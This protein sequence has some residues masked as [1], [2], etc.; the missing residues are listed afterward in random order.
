MFTHHCTRKMLSD[1]YMD[2]ILLY[3]CQTIF[4]L[5]KYYIHSLN[6]LG[7]AQV[8]LHIPNFLATK[9]YSHQPNPPKQVLFF[10]F[11]SK[12]EEQTFGQRTPAI[13]WRKLN[14]KV[15][16]V[17]NK[18]C[19]WW[20]QINYHLPHGVVWQQKI[21]QTLCRDRSYGRFK[22]CKLPNCS[23]FSTYT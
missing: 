11:F 22:Y 6:Q 2:Q 3:V 9:F 10:S 16:K 13:P 20:D 4:K 15:C 5:L 8:W 14:S 12:K 1:E 21:G 23:T 18:P 19:K 17:A 7:A